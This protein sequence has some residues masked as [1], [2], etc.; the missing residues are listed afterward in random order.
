[1]HIRHLLVVGL[2][3]ED[4][5]MGIVAAPTLT[6]EAV[7]CPFASRATEGWWH[8]VEIGEIERHSVLLRLL[9]YIS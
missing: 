7:Q 4:V 5:S 2:V 3:W 9:S 1:M 8:N 6:E